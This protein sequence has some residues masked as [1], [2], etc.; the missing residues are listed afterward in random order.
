MLAM[1]PQ[2]DIKVVRG[3]KSIWRS[4]IPLIQQANGR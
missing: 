3:P 4:I 1:A 2:G